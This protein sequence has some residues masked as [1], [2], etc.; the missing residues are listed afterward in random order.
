MQCVSTDFFYEMLPYVI[1]IC[2]ILSW[3]IKQ[4]VSF[5]HKA[6]HFFNKLAY[7]SFSFFF[8]SDL[9]GSLWWKFNLLQI[10]FWENTFPYEMI[11]LFDIFHICCNFHFF[12][13]FALKNVTKVLNRLT[14]TSGDNADATQTTP[15]PPFLPPNIMQ[16][17]NY[18]KKLFCNVEKHIIIIRISFNR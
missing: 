14:I 2:T 4:I 12:L 1:V 5:Y 10:N 8:V 9:I 16:I 3:N 17:I 6:S 15:P 7:K 18:A 11:L 13:L